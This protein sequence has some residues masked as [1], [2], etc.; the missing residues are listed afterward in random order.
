MQRYPEL[1]ILRHGETEWNREGRMQGSLDSPLTP[2]GRAQAETQNRILRRWGVEA[3]DWFVSPRGRTRETARIASGGLGTDLREDT[4]LAEIDMGRWTGRLREEIAAEA[5]HLF[6]E[7]MRPLDFY[8][9][10]PG[11]ESLESLHAR[12]AAF[13]AGLNAPAVIVTHGIASRILRCAALGLPWDLFDTLDGGQGVVYR[14]A[15]GRYEKLTEDGA[16]PQDT[17]PI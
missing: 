15:P 3:F 6:A 12:L 4:R 7:D 11:G 13:L 16:Q 5:P 17:S 9:S 1:L 8:R 2:L 10:I 14:L